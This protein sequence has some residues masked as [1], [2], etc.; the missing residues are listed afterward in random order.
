LVLFLFIHLF[1]QSPKHKCLKFRLMLIFLFTFAFK[2]PLSLK[3][4]FCCRKTG[5]YFRFIV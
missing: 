3:S 2:Q 5:Y 4:T 1:K